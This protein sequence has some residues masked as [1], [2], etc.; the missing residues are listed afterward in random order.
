M[1]G[2][3]FLKKSGVNLDS[4]IE[5]LGDISFY[6]E[7]L[8]QFIEENK[9]RLVNIA[10]YKQQGN[11]PEYAILVHALK[12]DSKYLGFTELADI[13]YTHEMAS[14]ANDIN[15][16]NQKYADLVNIY[17][18]YAKIAYE[19]LALI[20]NKPQTVIEE[21]VCAPI[22]DGVKKVIVA[23]DSSI[24]TNIV[25]KAFEGKYKVLVA[26]NGQQAVDHIKTNDSKDIV[27]L[28]LDLNMPEVDGFAV[29]DYFKSNNLFDQ[30]PVCI[31]TGDVE[32]ERIDRAFTYDIVDVLSKPFT[33]D[34]V[35]NVI[36]KISFK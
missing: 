1:N 5:L 2:T 28:I 24:I 27:A 21:Q 33:M 34:N 36:E 22:S 25:E 15:T 35:R 11:M 18:K 14:K 17:N 19:Y 7:T 6:D 29:L 26:S 23:D 20:A 30:I 9:T 3:D 10:K 4:A 32:R 13:A 16:V 12:S 8:K 31:I